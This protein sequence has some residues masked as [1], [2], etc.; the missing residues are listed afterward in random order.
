MMCVVRFKSLERLRNYPKAVFRQ[1]DVA[2]LT[3]TD[4]IDIYQSRLKVIGK[5]IV[6]NLELR[7]NNDILFTRIPEGL[8]D[9]QYHNEIIEELKCV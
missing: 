8:S 4:G 1:G 6:A 5:H 3:K 7:D 9:R 2:L